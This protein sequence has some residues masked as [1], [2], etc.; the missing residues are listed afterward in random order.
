MDTLYSSKRLALLSVIVFIFTGI[1][2]SCASRPLGP[3]PTEPMPRVERDDDLLDEFEVATRIT[4]AV[5][6][7]A[8]RRT[9]LR[10]LVDT[11]IKAMVA[12]T[13]EHG[14]GKL[15][16][17]QAYLSGDQVVVGRRRDYEFER[18]QRA[19]MKLMPYLDLETAPIELSRVVVKALHEKLGDQAIYLEAERGSWLTGGGFA[20]EMRER[21]GYL[22]IRL[23]NEA[24]GDR[25]WAVL[26]QWAQKDPSPRAIILDLSRCGSGAPATAAALV[27]VF[28]PGKK[29]FELEIYNNET[30]ELERREWPG[31]VSGWGPLYSHVPLFV[32]MSAH[33]GAL[34]EAIAHALRHHRTARVIGA[35]SKNN[36]R[37]MA[38][39]DLPWD[40]RWGFAI[41]QVVRVDGKKLQSNPVIPDFCA[42]GIGL[43]ALTERT[44]KR[45][46][47]Q[48]SDTAGT[49]QDEIV[50]NQVFALLAREEA[51]ESAA[52]DAS[53]KKVSEGES[54][55]DD[56]PFKKK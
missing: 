6:E 15:E 36:G 24:I 34:G 43:V 47:E 9:P 21:V 26:D 4:Y 23:L 25:I 35:V 2:L 5:D 50:F 3:E 30:G 14:R 55:D 33:T 49:I 42:G 56:V 16:P 12:F 53:I 37:I 41:A 27:N 22:S 19:A 10:E 7:L 18:L 39:F 11:Q 13:K 17:E 52:E 48:C 46:R 20:F 32:V 54:V 45:Y 1:S 51:G 8:L 40:A 38:W 28:A 44:I 31:E 29:G